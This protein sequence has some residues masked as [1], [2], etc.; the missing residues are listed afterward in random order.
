MTATAAVERGRE[1]YA[2]H[3]WVDAHESLS[4]ADRATALGAEDLELLARS[5]YMLGLD[6]EYVAALERAHR[7]HLDADH[8][9]ARR[10]LR[11]LDRPHPVPAR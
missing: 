1:S 11:F 5:A 9:A 8:D 6:D 4:E 2:K 10:A 3:A 7:A